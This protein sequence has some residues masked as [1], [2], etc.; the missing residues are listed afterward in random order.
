M[1]HSLK[2][3][4]F[5]FDGTLAIPT[6]DFNEMKRKAYEAVREVYPALP[7]MNDSPLLEWLDMTKGQVPADQFFLIDSID[8]AA[9]NA[10]RDVELEAA[11]RSDVFSWVRQLLSELLKRNITP[12]IITRNCT[13]AVRIVF[14]DVDKYCPVILTRDDVPVVKPD[15]DHLHRALALAGC[16]PTEA[17][18]T[19]DHLMDVHTGKAA[20][21]LTAGV[22]SGEATR[23]EFEAIRPDFIATDCWDLFLQI[24][25]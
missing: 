19:G 16:S 9:I 14:P 21:T 18:M 7:D 6:I 13:E 24:T 4:V 10:A 25:P 8:T 22:C 20:G 12:C 15:P 11:A 5:D 3:V 2:A 23:E 1:I 17:L